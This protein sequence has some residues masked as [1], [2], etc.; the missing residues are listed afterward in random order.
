MLNLVRFKVAFQASEG[1]RGRIAETLRQLL[2]SPAGALDPVSVQQIRV[3]REWL[4]LPLP[5]EIVAAARKASLR[6]VE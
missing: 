3:L 1:N 6:P 5:Q 2:V 4:V